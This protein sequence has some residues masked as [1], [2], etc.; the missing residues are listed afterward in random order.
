MPEVYFLTV[1]TRSNGVIANSVT[2]YATLK[3]AIEHWH[4]EM[5]YGINNES[6]DYCM[7]T[8]TDV[9]GAVVEGYSESWFAD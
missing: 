2:N 8:I 4:Y 7:A 3:D 5:Y 9:N 1:A 6:V